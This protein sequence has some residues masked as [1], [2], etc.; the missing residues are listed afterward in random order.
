MSKEPII[1][2]RANQHCH[3][4]NSN[5]L[6]STKNLNIFPYVLLWGGHLCCPY[7]D[8]SLNSKNSSFE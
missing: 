5:N 4:V 8:M 1:Y 2:E 6:N 7:L 3:K